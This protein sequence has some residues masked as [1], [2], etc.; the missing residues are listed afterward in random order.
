MFEI[1]QI[2]QRLRCGESLRQV[3]LSLHVGRAKVKLIHTIATSQHWLDPLVSIP[4]DCILAP[5]FA[6]RRT[7]PQNSSS[8]EAYRN[9]ILKWHAQGINATTIRRALHDQQGFCGSVHAIYRFLQHEIVSLPSATMKLDFP[10]AEMAQVDFGAGPMM[11]DRITGECFK[12]WIFVCTLAWSRHQYA[13]FVRDQSIA[14]WLSCHRHAFDWFN[15]V[16]KKIRIDNLKAAIVKACYYEPTVQRSYA[17][18]ALGYGFMIDPCPVADPKKKGRVEAGVKYVKN[19]FVPLREYQGIAHANTLLHAWIMEEA[20]QRIHGT[21]RERPLT[22]FVETEQALLQPLPTVVPE[23]A[24]WSKALLHPNCHV[25]F[26]Y[27]FY[28]APF[29]LIGQ[30]LWLEITPHMIRLYCDHELVALHPRLFKHGNKSTVDDH[31][32][33]DAQAYLMRNPQWCLAQARSIGTDCL[34]LVE[35]LFSDRVLDHLRAVQ[36]V[37]QLSDQYGAQ[38]VESACTRALA[39]GA[40]QFRTVKQILKQGLDQQPACAERVELEAPYL[41][42]GR[43]S[44]H[45]SDLLH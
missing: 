8:V 34:A 40:P 21:T 17:E 37:I 11:T 20:G 29:G 28:S 1:R 35:I 12:T 13:E 42:A 10:V 19:N 14:T 22:L 6:L 41:G 15:G 32:P 18:L 33:P 39:F 30:T 36:G 4:D 7:A 2:I 27:C 45:V 44:R 31:I 24:T 25:Q 38:R 26:E 43:F 23:C 16:P 3:A 5:F 9:D